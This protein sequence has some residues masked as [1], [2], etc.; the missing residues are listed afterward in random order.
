MSSRYPNERWDRDRFDS[1]NGPGGGYERESFQEE[2]D[3]YPSPPRRAPAQ[4]APRP[5][6]VVDERE[7]YA[8]PPPRFYEEDE[9][10]SY[11]QAMVPAGRRPREH[12]HEYEI[13]IRSRERYD[14]P[15]ERPSRGF[16]RPGLMRRPSSLDT[17][18]RKPMSRYPERIRE[19]V[20]P[21]PAPPRRRSPPRWRSP[22]RFQERDYYEDIRIA[23]PEIYG[24]EEFRGYREREIS[25][26][27]RNRS[28]STVVEERIEEREFPKKG[29]TKMPARLVEKKAIIQLGYPFEEEVRI[30]PA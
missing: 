12:D 3:Y 19:E 1:Y 17:H 16:Q 2:R 30:A 10:D 24:D 25:R 8:R 15:P 18:D 27:R 14:P 26:V 22:P 28:P 20:I 6:P 5:P 4:F 7:R 29:K 13:D 9:R 11:A 21:V 23:E